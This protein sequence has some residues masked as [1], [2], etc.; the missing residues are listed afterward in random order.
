VFSRLAL[1]YS[2]KLAQP[3]PE[4]PADS[5]QRPAEANHQAADKAAIEAPSAP[6]PVAPT[7]T[8]GEDHGGDYQGDKGD[9]PQQSVFDW[10]TYVSPLDTLAQW[11][12]AIFGT[13][14]TGISFWAVWLLRETLAAT[15]EAVDGAE[16]ATEA[17]LQT[18]RIFIWGRIEYTDAF[19][20]P[21][22][23]NFRMF[24]RNDGVATFATFS[25]G[26]DT[27]EYEE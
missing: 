16:K 7:E 27:D 22:W 10:G 13:V 3:V 15:R 14:A 17:A 23:V 8:A 24:Q 2:Q 11:I 5:D 18:V 20:D 25:E 19:K 1:G 9:D 26:N 21:H 4:R 6:A 12:M